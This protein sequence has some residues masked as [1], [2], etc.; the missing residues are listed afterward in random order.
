MEAYGSVGVGSAE[1]IVGEGAEGPVVV[2]RVVDEE[3][4]VLV[5]WEDEDP[6]TWA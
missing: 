4:T 1:S 2:G 6:W 5:R 3:R